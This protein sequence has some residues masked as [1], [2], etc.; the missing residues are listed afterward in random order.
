MRVLVAVALIIVVVA[1]LVQLGVGQGETACVRDCQQ[2]H[3][4]ASKTEMA[5]CSSPAFKTCATACRDA[6]R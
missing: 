6:A 3:C 2:A 5:D 4:I 1:V